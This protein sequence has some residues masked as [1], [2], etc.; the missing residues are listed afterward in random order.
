MY[1]CG[2]VNIKLFIGHFGDK[3][4]EEW[5]FCWAENEEEAMLMI[6]VAVGEPLFI[7]EVE[8]EPGF[9]CFKVHEEEE[10][11]EKFNVIKAH[12]DEL[13]FE[14]TGWIEHIISQERSYPIDIDIKR[15]NVKNDEF[16]KKYKE[17][18]GKDKNK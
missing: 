4:K 6:D 1:I 8:N 13:I 14:D 12:E 10:D 3:K 17:K 15:I 5:F 16:M 11:G 2:G 9:I 18:N 7:E